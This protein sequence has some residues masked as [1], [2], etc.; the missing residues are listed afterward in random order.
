MNVIKS[1]PPWQIT[2]DK[3]RALL[4]AIQKFTTS[5]SFYTWRAIHARAEDVGGGQLCQLLPYRT[6]NYRIVS[7]CESCPLWSRDRHDGGSGDDCDITRR[8]KDFTKRMTGK[9][10]AEVWK[11]RMGMLVINFTRFLE[12]GDTEEEL[13]EETETL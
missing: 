10:L 3:R 1:T 9:T 12:W 8:D 4:A 7:G 2:M 6:Y 13:H 5:P 11:E